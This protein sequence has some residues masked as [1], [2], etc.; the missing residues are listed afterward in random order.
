MNLK[1]CLAKKVLIFYSVIAPF[2][3]YGSLHNVIHGLIVKDAPS[4][5]IGPF[6]IF[7]FLIMPFLLVITYLRN[8]CI[9]TPDSLTIF[10]TVYKFSD[11][12]IYIGQKELPFKERPLTSLFKKT[13]DELLIKERSTNEVVEVK[14]LDVFEKDIVNIKNAISANKRS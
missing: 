6:S 5:R 12:D 2:I 10:K 1:I 13:Y 8:S 4:Y 9:I 3:M 14:D 7:G 11:Y